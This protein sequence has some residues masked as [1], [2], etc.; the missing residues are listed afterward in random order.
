[1]DRYEDSGEQ[2]NYTTPY[3]SNDPSWTFAEAPSP[4]HQHQ[5]HTQR[6]PTLPP[7]RLTRHSS[8]PR[9]LFGKDGGSIFGPGPP[10]HPE[11]S[12][13]AADRPPAIGLTVP[14][15]ENNLPTL[16]TAN[17]T[18]SLPSLQLQPPINIKAR[19]SWYEE[20]TDSVY[21]PHHPQH[22]HLPPVEKD[23]DDPSTPSRSSVPS[24]PPAE[25]E[26]F[27]Q[28]PVVVCL[29]RESSSPSPDPLS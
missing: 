1:M 27:V 3:Q 20:D 29:A 13:T 11:A 4:T 8:L 12:S 21:I 16:L 2:S 24:R 25:L 7:A 10:Q 26:Q 6:P 14:S 9:A 5:P 28:C 22:R 15:Q 23:T 18:H 17:T 19:E